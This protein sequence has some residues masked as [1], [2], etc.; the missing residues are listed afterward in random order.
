MR[1]DVGYATDVGRVRD[2]NEDS[3]VVDEQL[4][5]F[6]VADGMGGHRGGEVASTTAV[7][8]LRA[9]VAAGRSVED[10]IV[11]ANDAVLD[12]AAGE[13]G[14]AGMG[15]TLTAVLPLG[16]TQL[17]IGHV[18]DSRAYLLHA[19]AFERLTEDHSLVEE[20]VR[21]GRITREQAEVH[22]QRNIVTRALGADAEVA[23]DVQTIEVE[24]G[25]R[26]LICSDGLTTMVRER[27]VARALGRDDSVQQIADALVDDAL[28]NGGEDNVTVVVI[29]IVEAGGA[30]HAAA[31]STG[32]LPVTEAPTVANGAPAPDDGGGVHPLPATAEPGTPAAEASTGARTRRSWWRRARGAGLAILPVIVVVGVAATLLYWAAHR[33]YFVSVAQDNVAMYRGEPAGLLWWQPRVERI[34]PTKPVAA[35]DAASRALVTQ[36]GGWCAKSSRRAVQDC[37]DRLQPTTT[38][39]TTTRTST[40]TRST[41]TTRPTAATTTTV[42]R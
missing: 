21:E 1:L 2:G 29:A 35:L 25:D 11:G 12:R 15:T 42:V 18:G 31:M 38:T 13:P 7:E 36:P 39:T 22:P 32:E 30:P 37:I 3:F 14:L 5:L 19:G 28:R 8:A 23:V 9:A 27:D 20:L 40:T 17:L 33:T 4:G 24:T 26:V 34:D 41:T 10:A 6:A 16:D